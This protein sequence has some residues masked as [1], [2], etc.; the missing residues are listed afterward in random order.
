[1]C[2]EKQRY[3]DRYL[4]PLLFAYR[5]VPQASLGF[6]P[7]QL[8]YGQ[9][10][11]GPLAIL[12]KL[13]TKHHLDEEERLTYLH[14]FYLRNRLEETCRLAH[15]EFAKAG[16]RYA[17][18]YIRK[19]NGRFFHPGD[20]VLSI[21][22]SDNNKLLLQ[23]KGPFEDKEKEGEADYIIEKAGGR[24]IFHANV[25]KTYKERESQPVERMCKPNCGVTDSDSDGTIPVAAFRQSEGEREEKLLISWGWISRNCSEM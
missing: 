3:W 18:M 11:R 2:A 14:V 19:T 24:K 1:M 22:P 13:W 7:F 8:L 16:A 15:E 5:E 10:V 23:W 12:K 21:L 17:K 6:S 9:H 4:A 20:M 25:L